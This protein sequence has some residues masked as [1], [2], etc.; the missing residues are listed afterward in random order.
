[1]DRPLLTIALPIFNEEKSIEKTVQSI[2]NQSFDNI[3][4]FIS[5]N[6][7]TDNTIEIIER[8]KNSDSRIEIWKQEKN[9]GPFLNFKFLLDKADTKYFM[10]VG[11]H[12]IVGSTYFQEAVSCLQNDESVVAVYPITK[13]IG[14]ESNELMVDDFYTSGNNFYERVITIIKHCKWGSAFHSVFRTE[15]LRT[16]FLDING[17]DLYLFL[18]VA[19]YG[20]FTPSKSIAYFMHHVKIEEATEERD[21]RY[22]NYGFKQNWREI[23]SMYPYEVITEY[24]PMTLLKRI[25]L[26]VIVKD[27]MSKHRINSWG[28]VI[29]YYIKKGN[30][31][32]GWYAI[33]A[34]LKANLFDL[35]KSLIK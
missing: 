8:L 31:L 26:F 17:G 23:H 19:M 24:K 34:S 16:S 11:G 29:R 28:Q 3:R 30:F 33:L 25:S 18:R 35:P 5:D 13:M 4:I 7:S 27:L 12:D 21:K 9:I 14:S 32:A 1:M 10:W 15:S 20:N 22:F 2:L 6:C